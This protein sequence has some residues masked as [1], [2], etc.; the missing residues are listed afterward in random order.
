M[1]NVT[2]Q[3]YLS[4]VSGGPGGAQASLLMWTAVLCNN[5]PGGEQFL[6][7]EAFGKR[8]FSPALGRNVA[9]EVN[10]AL[11]SRDRQKQ[12]GRFRRETSS[13]QSTSVE[14]LHYPTSRGG[15]LLIMNIGRWYASEDLDFG[16]R[17]MLLGVIPISSIRKSF[18]VDFVLK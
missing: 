17:S 9:D 2:G 1:M 15:K 16:F 4:P 7:G 3:V 14:G 11:L 12:L 18:F 8:P 5:Q 13:V 6:K 10:W